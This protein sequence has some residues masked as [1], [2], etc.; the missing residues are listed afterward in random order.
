MYCSISF[1]RKYYRRPSTGK[2]VSECLKYLEKKVK[3]KVYV[4]RQDVI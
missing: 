3:K 4:Y 2:M 1:L